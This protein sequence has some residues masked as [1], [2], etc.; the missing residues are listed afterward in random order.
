M[1]KKITIIATLFI[2]F[3]SASLIAQN[4]IPNGGFE[5]QRPLSEASNPMGSCWNPAQGLAGNAPAAG[6][7]TWAGC[8]SYSCCVITELVA[9]G[10]NCIPYDKFVGGKMM[11][12]VTTAS[13]GINNVN[14]NS[15]A[16]PALLVTAR[17]YAVKGHVLMALDPNRKTAR[18]DTSLYTCKWETLRVKITNPGRD[19][20]QI[21]FYSNDGSGDFYV[22][23]ISVTATSAAFA[24]SSNEEP[25][26]ADLI[27]NEKPAA[28]VIKIIP[29]PANTIARI[30]YKLD[31][32]FSDGL[33]IISGFTG[34]ILQRIPIKGNSGFVQVNVSSMQPGLYQCNIETNGSVMGN[35]KLVV[36][37]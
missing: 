18:Y 30:D 36:S 35:T 22:D 5:T 3:C 33:L 17:V 14:I 21:S 11:H 20:N 25:T 27:V 16:A 6:W 4:L 13:T 9:E 10:S 1:K 15:A 31:N 8:T 37:R 28:G 26:A 19:I 23:S 34:T 32:N 12:V 24:N 29:N 7:L 2:F